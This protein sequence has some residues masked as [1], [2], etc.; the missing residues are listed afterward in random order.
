VV[1]QDPILLADFQSAWTRWKTGPAGW[2][3]PH[4]SVRRGRYHL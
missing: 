4:D 3:L 2:N 1:G